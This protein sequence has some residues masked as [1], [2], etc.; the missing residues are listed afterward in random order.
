M[1]L[2]LQQRPRDALLMC[3]VG[4]VMILMC[5][6]CYVSTRALAW[7][8]CFVRVLNNTHPARLLPYNYQQLQEKNSVII[9]DVVCAICL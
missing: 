5:D 6:Y 3:D 8:V 9:F 7:C 2:L 4:V 1:K